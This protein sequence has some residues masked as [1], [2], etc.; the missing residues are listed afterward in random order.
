MAY[1]DL[2][3]HLLCD[4]FRVPQSGFPLLIQELDFVVD[5]APDV[6]NVLSFDLGDKSRVFAFLGMRVHLFSRIPILAN[7][8]LRAAGQLMRRRR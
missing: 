3:Y 1:H 2:G 6:L 4:V 7:G 5:L 8:R